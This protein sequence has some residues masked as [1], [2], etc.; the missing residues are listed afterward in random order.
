MLYDH[1]F[2]EQFLMERGVSKNYS[3]REEWL[4]LGIIT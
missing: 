3:L 4:W 1:R 2:E